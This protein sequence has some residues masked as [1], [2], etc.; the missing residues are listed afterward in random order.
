MS[1]WQFKELGQP[2]DWVELS[3]TLWKYR[4]EQA[5]NEVVPDIVEIV[6]WND[7]PES[8]YI[9]DLNPKVNLGALAPS[10]VNG[11]I[12]APWRIIAQY[13]I[14]HFK[15]GHAPVVQVY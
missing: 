2:F 13:Y 8:H 14:T 15:T 11:F 12:H 10:Y 1:P 4:W 6:T 5:V 9:A 3:D 7:Y